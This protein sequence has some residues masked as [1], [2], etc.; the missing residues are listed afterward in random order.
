M[1]PNTQAATRWY[2]RDCLT[3]A[4]HR[5]GRASHRW[6]LACLVHYRLSGPE[7][8]RACAKNNGPACHCERRVLFLAN[9]RY[10]PFRSVN[11]L[12]S[13]RSTSK[14]SRTNGALRAAVVQMRG[15]RGDPGCSGEENL[16]SAG[17]WNRLLSNLPVIP[18]KTRSD[19]GFGPAR[20]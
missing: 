6:L 17:G 20:T 5:V 8:A 16:S 3:D 1:T 4:R 12:R 18:P 13:G 11:L 15:T 2:P 19:R 10:W 14:L 7:T 9:V